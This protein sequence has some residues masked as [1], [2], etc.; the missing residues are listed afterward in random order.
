MYVAIRRIKSAAIAFSSSLKG[1][2]RNH[3]LFPICLFGTPGWSHT[4]LEMAAISLFSTVLYLAI[5]L[6]KENDGT[7]SV[8]LRSLAAPESRFTYHYR[9][10]QSEE[11]IFTSTTGSKQD[12]TVQC[13]KLSTMARDAVEH[14]EN[15]FHLRDHP[16]PQ[17]EGHQKVMLVHKRTQLVLVA[18]PSSEE[19][20][21]IHLVPLPVVQASTLLQRY[22]LFKTYYTHQ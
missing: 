17:L 8:V 14:Q 7:N 4:V 19:A 21:R 5:A 9:H 20:S 6:H 22:A 15:I 16:D 13:N 11:V 18:D 12:L 1:F 10:S 2:V 3:Q